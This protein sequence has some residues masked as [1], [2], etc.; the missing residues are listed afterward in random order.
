MLHLNHFTLGLVFQLSNLL[1]NLKFFPSI[2]SFEIVKHLPK[3]AFGLIFGFN[4]FLALGCQTLLSFIVNTQ[5][6]LDPNKQFVI[7]GVYFL[8]ICIFYV[9][10][11]LGYL[12]CRTDRSV[13]GCTNCMLG[14]VVG[15]LNNRPTE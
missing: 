14:I 10:Y 4:S 9:L 15:R 3:D 1:L 7:Y 11:Q 6:G 13:F 5:L 12:L 2:A 8:V